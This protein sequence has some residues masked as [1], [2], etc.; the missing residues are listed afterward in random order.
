MSLRSI[1]SSILGDDED[2]EVKPT[3]RRHVRVVPRE[4]ER[5]EVYVEGLGFTELLVAQDISE[6][7]IGV[8]VPSGFNGRDPSASLKLLIHLPEH[9]Q[10]RAVAIAI[11]L[12]SKDSD[13]RHSLFGLAFT[14]LSDDA[15][16]KIASYVA[17]RAPRARGA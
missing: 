10:V 1:L 14:K 2:E 5:I 6:G 13:E 9:G 12:S 17:S 7:G 16:R 8:M 11:H 3:R 4:G 15:R